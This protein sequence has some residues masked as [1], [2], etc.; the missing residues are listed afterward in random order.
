M[1]GNAAIAESLPRGRATELALDRLIAKGLVFA[2]FFVVVGFNG[3]PFITSAG[4]VSLA[5]LPLL[6]L[7]AAAGRGRQAWQADTGLLLFFLFALLQQASLIANLHRLPLL[8]AIANVTFGGIIPLLAFVAARGALSDSVLA[9][10]AL[11]G[12][13]AGVLYRFSIALFVYWQEWGIPSLADLLWS[14][15]DQT[16]IAGFASATF[17]NTSSTSGLLALVMPVLIG[18]IFAL[19]HYP[20]RRLYALMILAAGASA[21]IAIIVLSRAQILTLGIMLAVIAFAWRSRLLAGLPVA[22]LAVL[23]AAAPILEEIDTLIDRFSTVVTVDAAADM[24]VNER[25][26][27]IELG[28]GLFKDKPW[29]GAG[30]G[31]SQLENRRFNAHQLNVDL[32]HELGAL[33]LAWTVALMAWTAWEAMRSIRIVRRPGSGVKDG[34]RLSLHLGGLSFMLYGALGNTPLADGL[35]NNWLLGYALIMGFAAT[36]SINTDRSPIPS[37]E[38]TP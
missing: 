25:I 19:R 2:L 29:F 27:S 1:A 37:G 3:R 32:A 33:G 23:I 30:Y 28:W 13:A 12:L 4:F 9:R 16:R 31:F 14:R 34:V 36:L 11:Y 22:F 7:T 26:E 17:G 35:T 20:D 10:V 8:D 21:M 38:Q 18:L 15:Y 24:S 5:V 6:F